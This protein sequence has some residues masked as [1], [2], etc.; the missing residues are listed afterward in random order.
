VAELR[1]MDRVMYDAVGKPRF[2]ALL[3]GTFSAL[4]LVLAAIGVYG[5][6]SYSVERRTRELGIRIALG[7]RAAGGRRI[8]MAG[9]A[10]PAGVRT[11]VGQGAGV[12]GHPGGGA[13]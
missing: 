6:M 9:G 10:R 4:A 5:V 13:Q 8:G 12:A 1:S 3:L 2:M 7:A 11:G